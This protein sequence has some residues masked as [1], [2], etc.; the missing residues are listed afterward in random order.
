MNKICQYKLENIDQQ[1]IEI[2]Y[3]AVI[4]SVVEQ[5]NDIVL[6]AIVDDEDSQMICID[7]LV[8][9][10][11]EVLDDDICLYVSIGTVKLFDGKEI[12]HVFYRR[13][14]SICEK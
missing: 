3:P 8:R 6:Y 12:W 11:G 2:P 13:N 7:I 10:T 4:H 9:G 5:N 1:T 14:K